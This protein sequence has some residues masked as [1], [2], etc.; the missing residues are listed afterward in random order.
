MWAEKNISLVEFYNSAL[1]AARDSGYYYVACVIARYAEYEKGFDFLQKHW[2]S[3][4]DLTGKEILLVVAGENVRSKLESETLV[5]IDRFRDDGASLVNPGI[6]I[7]GNLD[8]LERSDRYTDELM[9]GSIEEKL[10]NNSHT[11]QTTDLMSYFNIDESHGPALCITS[12][13]TGISSIYKLDCE[14]ERS[15]YNTIKHIKS[16]LKPALSTL[17]HLSDDLTKSI[18]N[19]NEIESDLEEI[20]KYSREE[21]NRDLLNWRGK[22]FG[23]SDDLDEFLDLFTNLKPGELPG[24][25]KEDSR[26]KLKACVRNPKIYQS[27]RKRIDKYFSIVEKED[28][29]AL[30]ALS[31]EKLVATESVDGL[32]KSIHDNEREISVGIAAHSGI[33]DLKKISDAFDSKINFGFTKVDIKL[34]S[35]RLAQ[36]FKKFS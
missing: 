11:T 6:T 30:S 31:S 19:L 1:D 21:L 24:I 34:L 2:A 3:F 33:E 5:K 28:P 12:L 13:I 27:G 8:W 17:I 23:P 4:H 36:F 35:K 29:N 15:L 14:N 7:S 16:H 26:K 22:K 18:Q 9:F 32:M 10:C 20:N 25:S